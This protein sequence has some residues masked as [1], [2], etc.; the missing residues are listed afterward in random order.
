MWLL[1][2]VTGRPGPQRECDLRQPGRDAF[3]PGIPRWQWHSPGERIPHCF[4]GHVDYRT[5]TYWNTTSPDYDSAYLRTALK[6]FIA[7]FGARY[8]GDPRIGFIHTGLVGL[9]GEWHTWPYD[10]DTGDGYPNYMPTDAHGAEILQ[11]YDNAFNKT[12]LEVR[13]PGS[14]GSASGQLDIGYHD[15]SFCYREGSPLAGVTLPESLGGA[16]YSQLQRAIDQGAENKWITDSMG[17][18]VRPEIQSQAFSFW[19]GGSGEVDNMKA[20]IELEHTTWK[21][22]EGSSGYSATDPK[23]AAGVRLMGY[24]LGVNNATTRTQLREPPRS[25]SRSATTAWPRST[26]PGR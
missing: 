12:K 1:R 19:P 13:Y 11:A 4:D 26:T 24:N 20:C 9:W 8:D 6:N 3:L 7:A 2:L 16:S 14:G 23:V 25:A 17:G 10:T 21:M 5:N 18:E 15:D 22:N